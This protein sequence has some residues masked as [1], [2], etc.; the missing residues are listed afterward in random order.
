MAYRISDAPELLEE[1]KRLDLAGLEVAEEMSLDD[2]CAAYN[3]VGPARWPAK[4]RDALTRLNSCLRPAILGH[5]TTWTRMARSFA[6]RCRAAGWSREDALRAWF[7]Y[8]NAALEYNCH[9]CAKAAYPRWY[10]FVQ[11]WAVAAKGVA[12]A[13]LC[14][15]FGWSAFA[16]GVEVPES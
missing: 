2:L 13:E 15:K 5:D 14:R 10:Q 16:E 3:G 9:L 4:L 11:R 6:A 8:T 12:F 7:V 1:A